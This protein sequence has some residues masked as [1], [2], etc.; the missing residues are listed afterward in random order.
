MSAHLN[1]NDTYAKLKNRYHQQLFRKIKLHESI[2][3]NSLTF[4]C[5]QISQGYYN[6]NYSRVNSML[7][8]PFFVI[9]DENERNNSSSWPTRV[10]QKYRKARSLGIGSRCSPLLARPYSEGKPR[11]REQPTECTGRKRV[12]SAQA[13]LRLRG[14][15]TTINVVARLSECL[16]ILSIEGNSPN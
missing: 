12:Q 5:V 3:I 13:H 4:W 6:L 15:R 9:F 2:R 7:I 16:R 14:Q 10:T 8:T 1:T 11:W